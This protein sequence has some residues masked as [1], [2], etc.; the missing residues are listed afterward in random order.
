MVTLDQPTITIFDRDGRQLDW[1]RAPVSVR[2]TPR[3]LDVGDAEIIV[4]PSDPRADLLRQPGARVRIELRGDH[5]LG[6]PVTAWQTKGPRDNVW[7]FTVTDDAAVLDRIITVPDPAKPLDQQKA[8]ADIRS[9]RLESVV[10][11]YVAANAPILGIPVDIVA[12]QGRGPNVTLSGRWQP[13]SEVVAAS[14][15]TAGMGLSVVWQPTT[16]RLL[17]DVVETRT[18]PI[19]LSPET[20]T[21]TSYELS[22]SAP[23]ATRVFLGPQD[24]TAFTT[25]TNTVAE[26]A[27]GPFL[28]GATFRAAT[29]I[30]EQSTQGSDA[31]ND[32]NA[33]SG[34][35]V[36]L[37]ETAYVRYGGP[38][39]LHVGDRATLRI[40]DVEVT[41]VVR[42][43]VIEWKAGAGLSVKPGVGAWDNSPAF[44][45]ADAVRRMSA[46]VRRYIYR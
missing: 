39:G 33:K 24:G 2:A 31:L 30:D 35:S 36:T 44:A 4:Q 19:Q 32:G 11:S 20:R 1:L 7:T 40:G 14:L 23:K 13:I 16:N 9:G 18:Y 42:E 5:V 37:A 45:L 25:A 3:Y 12:D 46:T 17:L 21:V 28:R 10:K 34:L 26:A 29:G 43:A 15:R 41:D 6:G 38:G 22:A 8:G 27:W